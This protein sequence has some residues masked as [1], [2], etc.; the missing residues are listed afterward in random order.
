MTEYVKVELVMLV[1]RSML[2][3]NK[4]GVLGASLESQ[5]WC[6]VP[7]GDVIELCLGEAGIGD[8]D[9]FRLTKVELTDKEFNGL[10][11]FTGW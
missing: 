10:P 9:V 1:S 3:N 5:G 4:D 8:G 2:D 7:P 11:E 6:I